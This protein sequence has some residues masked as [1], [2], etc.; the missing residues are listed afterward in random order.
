[1]EIEWES[2]IEWKAGRRSPYLFRQIAGWNGIK[3]HRAHVMPGRMLE[4]RPDH[5]EINISLGGELVTQKISA[6]GKL[7]RTIGCNGNICVTPA[8][9][10]ISAFWSRP[11][12]NMGIMLEPEFVRE[13]AAENQLSSNFDFLEIYRQEDPLVTQL[14]L[15]LLEEASSETPMGKL[16]AESLVQTLTLHVLRTYST[17]SAVISR[18]GGGLS[19]Y[20][21]KRVKE[22]IDANLEDDLGLADIAAV[23]ELSQFHFARAFRKTTGVT[24]Q[25]YVMQRRI[26]RAKEL[27]AD[28]EMPIVEI[29]LRTGFK[30]QSHFT[31]LF[32]KLTNVTPKTWRDLKLA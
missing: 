31:T 9:Q 10:P 8:G 23:A 28:H 26:D 21:L 32:R 6:S 18:A 22:F 1:M 11:I 14:G 12:E 4:H 17:A 3:M 2:E 24:P 19:G 16:Y 25:H 7:V 20:K 13:T 27:L 15:A 5:H 30:N 29:S